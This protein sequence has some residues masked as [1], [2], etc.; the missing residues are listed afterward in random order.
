M[1]LAESSSES[2]FGGRKISLQFPFFVVGYMFWGHYNAAKKPRGEIQSSMFEDV[3]VHFQP[4]MFVALHCHIF[5]CCFL[6]FDDPNGLFVGK[7]STVGSPPVF[8]QHVC[9][10]KKK[11]YNPKDPYD[12][13]I[14]LYHKNQPNVGN[15]TNPMDPMGVF[16][17]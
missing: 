8:S 13:Y 14:C 11:D 5:R 3:F 12:W 17:S 10:S 7:D 6:Y 15:Y 4:H 1:S 9:C 2:M 16:A